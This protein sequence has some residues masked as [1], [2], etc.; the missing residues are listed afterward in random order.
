M[1]LHIAKYSRACAPRYSETDI[2]ARSA[3]QLGRAWIARLPSASG[4]ISK[5]RHDRV[6]RASCTARL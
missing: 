1:N 5:P 4:L 6:S 2:A 3:K